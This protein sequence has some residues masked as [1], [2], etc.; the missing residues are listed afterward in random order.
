MVI[1]TKIIHLYRMSLLVVERSNMAYLIPWVSKI[2]SD[3]IDDFLMPLNPFM[4]TVFA[5]INLDFSPTN[6]MWILESCPVF[7]ILEFSS[8][9]FM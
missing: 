8:H 3:P 6:L 7:A 2:L 4:A 9:S 5:I 1:K